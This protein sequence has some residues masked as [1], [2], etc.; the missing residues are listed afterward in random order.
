MPIVHLRTYTLKSA[1]LAAQY[2]Q[3][4]KPTM[5]SIAKFN[6]KTRGVYLNETN[7]KQVLAIIEFRDEDDPSAKIE[8]YANSEAFKEDLGDLDMSAF[9]GVESTTLK[10]LDF[11]PG[12]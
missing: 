5:A 8:A 2:A 6:V 12:N 9:E 1:N 3:R 10:L 7:P 11:S 4:W